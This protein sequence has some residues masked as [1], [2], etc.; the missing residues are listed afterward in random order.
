LSNLS[1]NLN[2]HSEL[3]K[4]DILDHVKSECLVSLDP[5]SFS[6]H[7]TERFCILIIA[8]IIGGSQ[9]NGLDEFFG[10]EPMPVCTLLP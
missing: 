8:N 5:K 6:D 1:S 2:S 3:L 7:E 9:Y 4:Y 10:K